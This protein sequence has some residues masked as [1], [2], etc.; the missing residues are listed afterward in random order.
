M[1]MLTEMA[2]CV[3]IVTLLAFRPAQSNDHEP[4]TR[5][6]GQVRQLVLVGGG[7]GVAAGLVWR[8]DRCGGGAGV[9]G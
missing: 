1:I 4:G 6:T 9:R 7:A 3:V 8:R 2:F 5:E